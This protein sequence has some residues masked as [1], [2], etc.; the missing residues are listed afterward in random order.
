MKKVINWILNILIL[1]IIII[2]G[3][4]LWQNHMM[5]KTEV[6]NTLKAFE[7]YE[8]VTCDENEIITS[9]DNPQPTNESVSAN[10]IIGYIMFPSLGESTALLQGDMS[11]DQMAAMDRGVSHDPRSTMPGEEGNTVIAGHRELFFKNFLE[12]SE[13]DDVVLNVG[14]NIY[15]YK[16]ESFEVIDPNQADK[17]FYDNDEDALIMYTCYPI[18]AW[19]PFSQRMVVKAKPIAKTSVTDCETVTKTKAV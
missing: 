6:D 17:V 12:L 14:D 18:E 1:I 2:I 4:L 15:I 7:T 16:I 11:D 8:Q 19:K 10:Q 3:Y 5:K 9:T 13:G